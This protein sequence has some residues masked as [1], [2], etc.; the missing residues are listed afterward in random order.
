MV[1]MDELKAGLTATI[2]F[3]VAVLLTGCAT[4]RAHQAETAKW[5]GLADQAIAAFHAAPVFVHPVPGD[6]GRYHCDTRTVDLGTDASSDATRR[7]LSHELGH[8]LRGDCVEGVFANEAEAN[9][10]AVRVLEAWGLDEHEA[11][12]QIANMLL[13]QQEHDATRGMPGHDAC[14]E[15]ADLWRRFSQYPPRDPAKLAA[16]CPDAQAT[17]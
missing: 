8:H 1:T 2:L 6:R 16:L 4:I 5:Q 15:F 11:F 9:F 10:L 7:L 3:L 14:R 12:R 17:R 13:W